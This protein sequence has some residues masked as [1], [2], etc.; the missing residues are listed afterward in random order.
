MTWFQ[1]WKRIGRQPLKITQ[2]K[3]V[4]LYSK[5]GTKHKCKLIFANKENN[6]HLELEE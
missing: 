2:H 5:D 6:F 3:E 1:L 4:L